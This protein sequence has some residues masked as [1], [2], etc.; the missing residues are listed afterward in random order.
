VNFQ[1]GRYRGEN[2]TKIQGHQGDAKLK[3]RGKLQIYDGLICSYEGG[4]QNQVSVPKGV[5][6]ADDGNREQ[7]FLNQLI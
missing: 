5:G 2:S 6:T 4:M 7:W 1:K 3:Q